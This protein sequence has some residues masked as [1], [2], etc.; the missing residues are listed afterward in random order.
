MSIQ[1]EAMRAG[2]DRTI[3]AFQHPNG[4]WSA[5]ELVNHPTPSG[6]DRW[7]PSYSDKREWP[8]AE[9]A[10]KELEAML[11]KMDGT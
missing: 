2:A 7:L 1:T 10:K 6:C 9:T 5:V 3:H 8:D 4:K 11:A